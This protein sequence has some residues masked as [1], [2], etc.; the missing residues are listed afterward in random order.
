MFSV[1]PGLLL[2][3]SVFLSDQGL[4]YTR[5]FAR[6]ASQVNIATRN[7]ARQAGIRR[8]DFPSFSNTPRAQ[9]MAFLGPLVP[10]TS[11]ERL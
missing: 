3:S 6:R 5:L 2:S 4:R 9:P 1:A 10:H 8:D 7:F 11:L